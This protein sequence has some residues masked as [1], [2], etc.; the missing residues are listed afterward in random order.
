MRKTQKGIG[1]LGLVFL[2]V[3]IGVVGTIFMKTYPLY[4]N[5][6]KLKRAVTETIN[7]KPDALAS[8]GA[9][10]GAL[11]R[12]WDVDDIQ[13]LYPKDVSIT[14]TGKGRVVSYDYYARADLF[15]DVSLI[16]HFKRDYPIPG[17]QGGAR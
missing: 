1:F 5:E 17:G 13:F 11:N 15:T 12:W 16:V 8:V 9:F 3:S 2:L 14:S 7:N 6:L 4:T 10:R